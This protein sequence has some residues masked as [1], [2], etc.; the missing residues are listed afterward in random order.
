M[1]TFPILNSDLPAQVERLA[2]MK[3][4]ID[5]MSTISAELR[6]QAALR[7][8]LLS[9][10]KYNLLPSDKVRVFRERSRRWEGPFTVK[11]A[12]EKEVWVND[13][14]TSNHFNR[15]QIV[16]DPEDSVT[17]NFVVYS[18]VSEICVQARHRE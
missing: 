16:L 4:S 2:A 17:E 14:R 11:W 3:D 7:S 5:D 12:R 1:P 13:D 6:I 8:S 18:W 10:I 15:S 9:P